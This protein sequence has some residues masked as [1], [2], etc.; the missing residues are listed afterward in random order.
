MNFSQYVSGEEGN[1]A[2]KW[3]ERTYERT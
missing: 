3:S 2:R 1:T